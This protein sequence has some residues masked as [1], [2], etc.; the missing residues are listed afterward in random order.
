MG[1]PGATGLAGHYRRALARAVPEAEDD[2]R[3]GL[4]LA[5]A[6]FSWAL[7]RLERAPVLDAREPGHPSRLQLIAT[8]EAAA[9]TAEAH[10]ALPAL[11]GWLRR[12]AEVLRRRWPDADQD[13][14]DTARFPPYLPRG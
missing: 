10:S 13:F 5:S 2:A 14:T 1:D 11:A 8:L 4:A 6:C 9:G 7:L 3:Y 12:V